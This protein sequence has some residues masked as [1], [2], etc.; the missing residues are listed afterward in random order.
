MSDI[1]KL[2]PGSYIR[3]MYP[4]RIHGNNQ[5]MRETNPSEVLS[6]LYTGEFFYGVKSEDNLMGIAQD[7]NVIPVSNIELLSNI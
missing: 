4:V 2:T 5:E 6:I 7:W 1:P 3:L